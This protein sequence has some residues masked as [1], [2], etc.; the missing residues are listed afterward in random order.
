MKKNNISIKNA[1]S[2]SPYTWEDSPVANPLRFDTNTLPFPPPGINI[3]LA[4]MKNMCPINEYG[5]PTYKELKQLLS[6]YEQISTDMITITNSGDEAI[7]ILAKAFLNPGDYFVTTP[8]TYE[9]FMI[10]C[11]INNGRLREVP[12]NKSFKVNAKKLI[13]ESK[14][15]RTKILFLVNPNNPTGSTIPNQQ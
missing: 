1:L 10:Q 2:V 3:F 13:W 9:M 8:P 4:E 11:I 15:E 7:D 5:N 14:R 6:E 12:L